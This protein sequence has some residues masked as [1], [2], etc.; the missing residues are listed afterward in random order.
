MVKV[1]TVKWK[2]GTICPYLRKLFRQGS[3]PFPPWVP[4]GLL[5]PLGSPWV[6]RSSNSVV[7]SLIPAD[8][9]SSLA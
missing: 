8:T 5:G 7:Y 6:P 3:S 4:L 1:D 9:P 2:V